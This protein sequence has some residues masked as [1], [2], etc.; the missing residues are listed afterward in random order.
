MGDVIRVDFSAARR[1]NAIPA[2][3]RPPATPAHVPRFWD[4]CWDLPAKSGHGFASR[5]WSVKV[6]PVGSGRW[7]GTRAYFNGEACPFAFRELPGE[8]DV[9]ASA[10]RAFREA[11]ARAS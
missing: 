5:G 8:A 6:R 3:P 9:P 2:A 4:A 10:W 11:T 7:E 1:G